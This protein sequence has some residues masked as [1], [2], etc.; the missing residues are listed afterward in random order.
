LGAIGKKLEILE[1]RVIKEEKDIGNNLGGR[2]TR[3]RNGR[4]KDRR[5]E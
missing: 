3:T 5:V 4:T 1:G 2:K